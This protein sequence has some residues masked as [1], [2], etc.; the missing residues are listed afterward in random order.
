MAEGIEVDRH[1]LE[2]NRQSN[3][4]GCQESHY[5]RAGRIVAGCNIDRRPDFDFEFIT[6]RRIIKNTH[7]QQAAWRY[8]ANFSC[9]QEKCQHNNKWSFLFHIRRIL[10]SNQGKTGSVAAGNTARNGY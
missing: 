4:V 3:V 5:E 6:I 10:K 8:A 1:R 7:I 9:H 2:R